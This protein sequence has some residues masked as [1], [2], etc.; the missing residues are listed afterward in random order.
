MTDFDDRGIATPEHD[1]IMVA[2]LNPEFWQKLLPSLFSEEEL[3]SKSATLEEL[4]VGEISLEV[5]VNKTYSPHYGDEVKTII[6]Y[7]DV[8]VP[9]QYNVSRASWVSSVIL[10][11]IACEIKTAAE[12]S[13]GAVIRQI[14][15]YRI[16]TNYKWLVVHPFPEWIKALETQNIH[17]FLS[18]NL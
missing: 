15:K 3:S 7:I 18:T 16:Y 6:G 4:Q 5:P 13:L 14:Q 12:P 10:G 17:S 1:R 8:L 11:R 2:L 9:I